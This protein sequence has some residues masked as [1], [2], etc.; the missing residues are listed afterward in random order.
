MGKIVYHG[1]FSQEA[2]HSYNTPFHAGTLRASQERLDEEERL[3]GIASIHGYEIS[4]KAPTSRAMWSDPIEEYDDVPNVVPEYNQK[5]IY[6]YRNKIEDE[7]STSYVIPSKFVGNHVKHLGVQFQ[8]LRGRDGQDIG[9]AMQGM[10]GGNVFNHG[11][12]K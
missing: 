2:P 9:K 1:T 4:D 8:A 12:P 7:G 3:G 6:P 5:R 11:V 10:V